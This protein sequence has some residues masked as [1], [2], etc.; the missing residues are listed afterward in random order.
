MPLPNV[1][2]PSKIV[3]RGNSLYVLLPPPIKHS[4]NIE[5][6]EECILIINNQKKVQ[7]TF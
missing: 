1:Q 3:K 5:P 7:I 4:C 6:G 2:I